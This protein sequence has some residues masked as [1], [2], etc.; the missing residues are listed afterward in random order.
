MKKPVELR[1]ACP[2][3]RAWLKIKSEIIFE[4]GDF[5]VERVTHYCFLCGY[6]D[7]QEIEGWGVINR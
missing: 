6:S 5:E 2:N 7:S 1:E 3:C 4:E